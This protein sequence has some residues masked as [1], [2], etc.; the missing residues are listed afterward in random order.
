[1]NQIIHNFHDLNFSKD[2][3]IFIMNYLNIN[4]LIMEVKV[5]ISHS[6]I[7]Q[8]NNFIEFLIIMKAIFMYQAQIFLDFHLQ[9][10]V[11]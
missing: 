9:S 5:I 6:K 1:M 2:F 7:N 8:N 10:K 11:Y 4:L 3:N